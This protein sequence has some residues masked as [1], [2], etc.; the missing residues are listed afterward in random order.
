MMNTINHLLTSWDKAATD[1]GYRGAPTTSQ[2]LLQSLQ[3]VSR[4]GILQFERKPPKKLPDYIVRLFA[5]DS[6]DKSFRE[7]VAT[8]KQLYAAIKTPLPYEEQDAYT[9][10][11]ERI[12]A[13]GRYVFAKRCEKTL[14]FSPDPNLGDYQIRHFSQTSHLIK[15]DILKRSLHNHTWKL[16]W[17]NASLKFL[18]ASPLYDS[19]LTTS[20]NDIELEALRKSLFRIIE[21]LRKNWDR[22]LINALHKELIQNL[23]TSAFS[24]FFNEQQDA[25]EFIVQLTNHFPPPD[26]EQIG[27]AKLYR[28]FA[29][30]V[31]KPGRLQTTDKLQITPNNDL[32]FDIEQAYSAESHLENV[33]EYFR[34]DAPNES[35]AL[36]DFAG[37]DAVTSFPH[38]LEIMVKRSVGFN[39]LQNDGHVSK[40]KIKLDEH[41]KICV[42]EHEPV[43]R[44]INDKSYLVDVKPKNLC[45]F[46]AVAAIERCGGSSASGHYIA[47]T[48]ALNGTITTH[49]DSRISTNKSEA[50][51][52]NAYYLMLELT[53]RYAI[54]EV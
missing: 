4:D 38:H 5:G 32:A 36:L 52:A 51:W 20:I 13:L 30:N 53:D 35:A 26:R 54:P 16:C 46:R 37:R 39:V 45:V 41:G 2:P 11:E 42:V 3:L 25:D 34:D 7:Q 8:I 19:M 47:H 27:F 14:F 10:L 44:I 21:A 15:P 48:R 40:A 33:R 17:L 6:K 29:D 12:N 9:R 18:A 23:R 50:V 24:S 49:D 1:A 28:S 31:W 43:Y 22:H